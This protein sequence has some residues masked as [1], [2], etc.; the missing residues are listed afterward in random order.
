MPE[1][2]K[3]EV[4]LED[5]KYQDNLM[6]KYKLKDLVSNGSHSSREVRS[7]VLVGDIDNGY[8]YGDILDANATQEVAKS[9]VEEKINIAKQ[10]IAAM[11]EQSGSG[12]GQDFSFILAQ[13]EGLR[14]KNI[15][16]DE[17]DEE[18]LQQIQNLM[19]S[20]HSNTPSVGGDNDNLIFS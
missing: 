5:T 2:L 3:V 15:L 17:K 18:I 9:V 7:N 4:L 20:I 16:Q 13:L 14:D 12:S 6:K 19:N 10:E 8:G 11:I 1:G